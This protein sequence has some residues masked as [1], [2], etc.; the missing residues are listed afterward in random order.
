MT[1]IALKYDEKIL[2]TKHNTISI[3]MT[4][5]NHVFGGGSKVATELG[6]MLFT[7]CISG[8]RVVAQG[9][10]KEI[11]G[12]SFQGYGSHCDNYPYSYL[13]AAAAIGMTSHDI[14]LFIKRLDKVM[15]ECL[16]RQGKASCS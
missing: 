8:T 4:V 14:E 6:S 11:E 1:R 7:R 15:K 9:S 12:Y 16:K 2:D 3:A 13:T 5:S 10:V